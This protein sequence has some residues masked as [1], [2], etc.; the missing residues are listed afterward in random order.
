MLGAATRQEDAVTLRPELAEALA[1]LTPEQRRHISRA[2][3][4]LVVGWIEEL[5][6]EVRAQ[7]E[8]LGVSYEEVAIAIRTRAEAEGVTIG[9]AAE[10]IGRELRQEKQ[11]PPAEDA[12]RA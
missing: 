6:T 1:K 7:A 2:N 10:A 3:A 5:A 9:E 11:M 8:I 4:A 12:D